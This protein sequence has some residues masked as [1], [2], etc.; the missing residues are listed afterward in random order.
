MARR[1][2]EHADVGVDE[3]PHKGLLAVVV[4]TGGDLAGKDT[5]AKAVALDGVEVG[6]RLCGLLL[7][8]LRVRRSAILLVELVKESV[9]A[10]L[11][12]VDVRDV[13]RLEDHTNAVVQRPVGPRRAVLCSGHWARTMPRRL[14]SNQLWTGLEAKGVKVGGELR[15]RLRRDLSLKDICHSA[16]GHSVER[17]SRA[18]DLSCHR[19]FRAV[20][21]EVYDVELEVVA[22]K[23]K[24]ES[25]KE[26]LLHASNKRCILQ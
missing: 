22:G 5:W 4:V 19:R 23:T 6:V 17:C 16:C 13:C 8:V 25:L 11:V 24:G 10:I 14:G 12:S 7:D 20:G 1:R 3:V 9:Q 26:E 2:A 15:L 21:G 18:R